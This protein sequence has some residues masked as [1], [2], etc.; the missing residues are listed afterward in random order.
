MGSARPHITII[1]DKAKKGAKLLEVLGRLHCEDG[2]DFLGPRFDSFWG[3]PMSKEISF[4]DS[5]FTFE[6]VDDESFGFETSKDGVDE[7][8]M[9]LEIAAEAGD[10]VDV[11]FE[12]GDVA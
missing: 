2:F 1:C 3:E 9:S 7:L 6:W 8:E 11:Y 12:V 10:V 5:P 4:L